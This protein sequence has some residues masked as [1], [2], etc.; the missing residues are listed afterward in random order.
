[1]EFEKVD[2]SSL[3][4][5]LDMIS[6]ALSTNDTVP[7]LTNFCFDDKN[8][9]LYAFDGVM[10]LGIEGTVYSGIG[11]G[12]SNQLHSV[13][14]AIKK[15]S[16]I[17]MVSSDDNLSIRTKGNTLKVP[18]VPSDNFLF[19]VPVLNAGDKFL[20]LEVN[21]GFISDLGLLLNVAD[22]NIYNKVRM[23]VTVSYNEDTGLVLYSADNSMV[24]RVTV[25]D[26]ILEK[27]VS[28]EYVAVIPK[29]FCQ[30][31][32][33]WFNTPASLNLS[34]YDDCI[35]GIYDSYDGNLDGV[36][37]S[38]LPYEV[39]DTRKLE[40]LFRSKLDGELET[41]GFPIDLLEACSI[42]SLMGIER[43]IIEIMDSFNIS[44][45]S[46]KKEV[47]YYTDVDGEGISTDCDD[48]FMVSVPSILKIKSIFGG[49]LGLRMQFLKDC[50]YVTD[51]DRV[52]ILV[53]IFTDISGK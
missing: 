6:P 11:L 15:D 53:S 31:I 30:Q 29:N 18:V 9:L 12:V 1:M 32:K 21:E 23:G 16:T 43:L 7:V 13:L 14:K 48:S 36:M 10:A 19:D 2:V 40:P 51:G 28:K 26:E 41:I 8:N 34:F 24:A 50:I 42:A 46:E 52:E 3:L 37:F 33:A 35:L 25:D 38:S 49:V 44:I 47:Q 20:E 45:N 4:G 27:K 5:I 22:E 39:A 17:D